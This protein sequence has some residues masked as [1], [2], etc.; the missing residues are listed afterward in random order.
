MHYILNDVVNIGKVLLI[1]IISNKLLLVYI[2]DASYFIIIQENI[3]N[4][5]QQFIAS[6]SIYFFHTTILIDG[7]FNKIINLI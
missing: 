6:G 4:M 7:Y 3:F 2:D 1:E 5:S